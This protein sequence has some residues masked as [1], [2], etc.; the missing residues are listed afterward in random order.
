MHERRC[1]LSAIWVF[2]V[3]WSRISSASAAADL[4]DCTTASSLSFAGIQQCDKVQLL[5]LVSLGMEN[6]TPHHQRA[7]A[8]VAAHSSSPWV[9]L[10][11]FCTEV[12]PAG[13]ASCPAAFKLRRLI[14]RHL[15]QAGGLVPG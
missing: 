6:C 1:K 4:P 11:S 14:G 7:V 12:F 5:L 9:S 8:D 3:F 2:V 13:T 10:Y 15:L